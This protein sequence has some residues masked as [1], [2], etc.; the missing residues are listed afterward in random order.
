M[1]EEDEVEVEDLPPIPRPTRWGIAV[2]ALSAVARMTECAA[3]AVQ[4]VEKFWCEMAM[5][6]AGQSN[7]ELDRRNMFEQAGREIETLTSG[8]Y[9]ASSGEARRG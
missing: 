2:I 7:H 9:D 6:A 3:E 8:A 5:A 4:V 1:A